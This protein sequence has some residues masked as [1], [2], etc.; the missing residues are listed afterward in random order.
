MPDFAPL[1]S[2]SPVQVVPTN[3]PAEVKNREK[4]WL[5]YLKDPVVQAGILQ[6]TLEMFQPTARGQSPLGQVG[7]AIASGGAAARRVQAQ[8]VAEEDRQRKIQQQQFEQ[9]VTS[10]ELGL[11]R[12]DVGLRREEL[13]VRQTQ[14]TQQLLK[15]IQDATPEALREIQS[16]MDAAETAR[17][18]GNMSA[19]DRINAWLQTKHGMTLEEARAHAQVI[20]EGTQRGKEIVSGTSIPEI[21]P[22]NVR[23]ILAETPSKILAEGPTGTATPIEVAHFVLATQDYTQTQPIINPETRQ[24]IGMTPGNKLTPEAE[25][26]LAKLRRDSGSGSSSGSSNIPVETST[27]GTTSTDLIGTNLLP[28]G[29]TVG[30][31]AAHGDITGPLPAVA[32]RLERTPF[33]GGMLSGGRASEMNAARTIVPQVK[34]NLVRILQNNPRFS[35]AE[36]AAIASELDVDAKLWDNPTALLERL[37]A[38]DGALQVRRNQADELAANKTI[39]LDEQARARQNVTAIDQFRQILL[40]QAKATTTT[41]LQQLRQ[42]LAPGTSIL[43]KVGSSWMIVYTPGGQ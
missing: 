5:E 22:S 11:R 31:L 34:N 28:G 25:K 7:S 27:P 35:E 16:G 42:T 3:D 36:R 23:G 14:A 8:G 43:V 17:A 6:F 41:E 32:T 4:G 15:T 30:E 24:V 39:S 1:M 40:P 38:I 18:S 19:V 21:T 20:A 9:G 33:V 12:E 37:V 13:G 10:E 29:K 2:P 26:A